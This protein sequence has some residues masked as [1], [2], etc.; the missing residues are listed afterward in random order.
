MRHH[1]ANITSPQAGAA[2]VVL[3]PFFVGDT[4]EELVFHAVDI[5][6]VVEATILIGMVQSPDQTTDQSDE[7]LS[8]SALKMIISAQTQVYAYPLN[9]YVQ[10]DKRYL[11]V[12]ITNTNGVGDLI[13]VLAVRVRL[14]RVGR[15]A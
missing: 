7:T 14:G 11:S 9:E 6:N 3:G 8:R 10:Q 13:G 4:L 15:R 5:T 1:A 12:T 2:T